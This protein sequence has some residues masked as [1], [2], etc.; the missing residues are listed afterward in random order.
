MNEQP[1]QNKKIDID[2]AFAAVQ[3]IQSDLEKQQKE[4]V[5]IK[6]VL[7]IV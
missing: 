7:N 1:N 3:R 5:Q 2:N 4:I 6:K